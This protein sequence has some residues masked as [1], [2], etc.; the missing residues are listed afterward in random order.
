MSGTSGGKKM[1]RRTGLLL[2]AAALAVALGLF[3]DLRG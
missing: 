3:L 2:A 1:M